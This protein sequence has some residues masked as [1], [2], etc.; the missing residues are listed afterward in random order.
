MRTF[1]DPSTMTINYP[2]DRVFSGDL[3]RVEVIKNTTATFVEV[4][5]TINGYLYKDNLY[6]L[7][8]KVVFSMSDVF[9]LLYDRKQNDT[10]ST[11][12][13]LNITFKLYNNTTLIDTEILS[14][15][16]I[17]LGKR[18]VFD[19][20]GKVNEFNSFDYCPKL[21]LS[22][23]GFLFYRPSF[24]TVML[25]DASTVYLGL[26]QE[27]DLIDLSAINDPID[28]IY[29]TTRNY[30]SNQNLQ[31]LGG[32]NFWTSDA[33]SGCSTTFG[34]TAANKLQFIM[35]DVSCGDTLEID[36]TKETFEVGKSYKISVTIDAVTNPS[37]SPYG[38]KV[39]LGGN[40]SALIST[41]GTTIVDVVC[42]SGGVLKLI[43]YFD[44][45]TVGFGTHSFSAT[46]L[47]MT[48][49]NPYKIFLNEVCQ[50]DDTSRAIGLRFLNRFGVWKY[51]DFN[52]KSENIS[53][54]KG[55]SLL[56]IDDN[57]TEFNGLYSEQQ[58][59][60]SQSIIVY[61]DAVDKSILND[62]SDI[63]YS[64]YKHVYD[65]INSVWIPVKINTNSFNIVERENLFDVSLNILMQSS[66]E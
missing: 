32:N 55:T 49:T 45:D 62:I 56:F 14:I 48:D 66:N 2:D 3:N 16:H 57:L 8:S 28:Y 13:S 38:I 65:D 12:Q 27:S 33:F 24:V 43:G 64:D 41:I 25:K 31:F 15:S 53:S 22:E 58:K 42:G 5:F 50:C 59:E 35:P 10:F 51:Y 20:I 21:G 1:T 40:E 39:S 6:F 46:T 30:V 26:K 11:D 44:A 52:V 4:S 37:S 19:E 9:K 47:V 34:I 29:Y 23:F 61:K 18:R 36:Y 7:T 54:G 17:I 63:L 60:Y